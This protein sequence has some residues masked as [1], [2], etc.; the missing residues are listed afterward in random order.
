M[1][2]PGGPH[3]G[4]PSLW[5]DATN[6]VKS[7]KRRCH[8]TAREAGR[9][10]SSRARF[11]EPASLPSGCCTNNYAGGP[12][13]LD[14]AR[15]YSAK[16]PA[17]TPSENGRRENTG[18]VSVAMLG[19]QSPKVVALGGAHSEWDE[20]ELTRPLHTSQASE[21]LSGSNQPPRLIDQNAVD[22][23]EID[24]PDEST[25]RSLSSEH[26][27]I[28]AS[29]LC[30]EEPFTSALEDP[31][32]HVVAVQRR[33]KTGTRHHR[34]LVQSGMQC[35]PSALLESG[36]HVA[37]NVTDVLRRQCAPGSPSSLLCEQLEAA[38]HITP[39]LAPQVD[40]LASDEK[41]VRM[42]L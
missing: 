15:Q 41:L 8:E 20:E 7:L 35:S 31:T 1:H 40:T 5:I 10:L 2:Q 34:R 27:H 25:P 19:R 9:K 33:I 13:W 17:T 18:G 29:W 36:H 22:L 42:N 38:V 11:G 26:T 21:G 14:T 32:S 28:S 37:E 16:R 3:L 23:L 4:Y 24:K 30:L 6:R 39:T 12:V